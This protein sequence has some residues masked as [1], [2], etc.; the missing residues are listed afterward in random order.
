MQHK[1]RL[2]GCLL[3]LLNTYQHVRCLRS[4]LLAEPSVYTSIGRH[5]FSYT[6]HKSGTPYL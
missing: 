6:P 2:V 3:N 1:E 5:T 4:H